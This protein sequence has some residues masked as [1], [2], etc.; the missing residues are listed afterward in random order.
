M[1][2]HAKLTEH[3]HC[4]L[5][6]LLQARTL[7]AAAADAYLWAQSWVVSGLH[8]AGIVKPNPAVK[9]EQQQAGAS[10]SAGEAVAATAQTARAAV[11]DPSVIS[12]AV[13]QVA[14]NIA[15]VAKVRSEGPGCQHDGLLLLCCNN[16]LHTSTSVPLCTRTL[17]TICCWQQQPLSDSESVWIH[18]THACQ[19][20]VHATS[21]AA[22]RWLASVKS[23]VMQEDVHR[24]FAPGK[25]YFIKRLDKHK[26]RAKYGNTVHVCTLC[27]SDDAIPPADHDHEDG[28]DAADVAA[29]SA[30]AA[31][32]AAA[33]AAAGDAGFSSDASKTSEKSE[34]EKEFYPGAKFELIEAEPQQR[35]ER[36]V[37][38]ETCLLDHLTGGY[39]Q[40]LRYALEQAKQKA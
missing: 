40:G 9:Q 11:L 7:A 18:S 32:K 21:A 28:Q 13:E 16:T 14:E 15:N 35:F 10:H 29:S 37:L 24:V 30:P 6:M 2:R 39:I 31:E 23:V 25:I 12:G 22:S 5:R 3:L 19:S 26:G 33:A 8:F 4:F 38:R 20:S 27:E 36:I 17:Y 1:P 34:T